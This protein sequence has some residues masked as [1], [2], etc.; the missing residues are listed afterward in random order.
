MLLS[1]SMA[2]FGDSISGTSYGI[3]K[4]VLSTL[5]AMLD[6][7]DDESA[8]PRRPAN[9]VSTNFGYV[10]TFRK[11]MDWNIVDMVEELIEWIEDAVRGKVG[12]SDG[13]LS[14]K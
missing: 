7:E 3:E 8:K 12:I 11:G 14:E 2:I 13:V 9:T 4:S 1:T 6:P 10:P 5:V